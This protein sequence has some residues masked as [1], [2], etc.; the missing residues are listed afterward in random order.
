MKIL[1]LMLLVGLALGAEE[2]SV[3]EI[4]PTLLLFG[5]SAGNVLTSIG[6]DG[7]LMI[8]TPSASSTTYPRGRC[9]TPSVPPTGWA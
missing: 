1:A 3:T 5:T 8:G 6:P 4:S 7:A 2:V 9:S